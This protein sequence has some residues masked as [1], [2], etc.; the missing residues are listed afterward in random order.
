MSTTTHPAAH[1]SQS[2]VDGR[3]T[4]VK[5]SYP[6]P[7]PLATAT[8]LTPNEARAVTEALNP[9]VADLFALYV[10]TKNFSSL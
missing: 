8:D 10:K 3:H 2:R 9:L 5:Q 1:Q 7:G 6:A 4:V